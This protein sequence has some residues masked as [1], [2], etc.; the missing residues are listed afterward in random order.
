MKPQAITEAAPDQRSLRHLRRDELL[1]AQN[2]KPLLVSI[3]TI[4]ALLSISRRR[5]YELWHMRVIRLY[6]LGDRLFGR[7]NEIEALAAALPEARP[8]GEAT[9][10]T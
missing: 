3:D 2:L 8:K 1:T 10:P 5:V 7:L 9:P 6:R 4:A